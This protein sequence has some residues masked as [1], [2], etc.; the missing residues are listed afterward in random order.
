MVEGRKDALL[1]LISAPSGAGKTTV[2]QNLLEACGG[3]VTRAVTCTTRAPR[4]GEVEGRDYYFLSSEEFEQRV[5]DGEFLEHATVY[6][7]SYGTLKSEILGKLRGGWDVLLNIDV[8]GAETIRQRARE[9]QDLARALVSIFLTA[10]SL[11]ELEQRLRKRG[12]NS[13][14]DMARRLG[15]AEVELAHWDAFDYLLVSDT[16]EEDLRRMKVILESEKM[17]VARSLPPEGVSLTQPSN[18]T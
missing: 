11:G 5:R 10:P 14:E 4:E 8:Q 18:P 7:R 6:G 2:C 12:S 17:R 3:T 13:E 1:I 16:E 9:D 15:H